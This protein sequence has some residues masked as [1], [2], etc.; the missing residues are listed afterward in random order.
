MSVKKNLASLQV[1]EIVDVKSILKAASKARTAGGPIKIG[2]VLLGKT[3]DAIL[4]STFGAVLQISIDSLL[5]LDKD[6][7]Q[8]SRDQLGSGVAV[9]VSVA[10]DAEIV[11]LR[12]LRAA[13]LR[14]NVGIR[15]LAF[16]LPSATGWYRVVKYD[17]K[18]PRL[19]TPM[20]TPETTLYM[21]PENTL[22]MTFDPSTGSHT[23]DSETDYEGD[24]ETDNE[25]DWENDDKATG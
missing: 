9:V 5:S 11:E 6:E 8:P 16:A 22:S 21:T 24:T 20:V 7:S 14:S 10:T 1:P 15:P 19:D 3:R 4:L 18:G 25:T 13:S 2:G 23:I 17:K 12:A